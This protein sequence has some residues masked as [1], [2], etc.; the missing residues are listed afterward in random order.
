M[1]GAE[2]VPFT[3][4][5]RMSGIEW[6]GRSI[7]KGAA[8]SV[9]RWV[10][11]QGGRG[12]DRPGA[13]V[14]G[15]ATTGGTP[16]VVAEG[17]RILGVIHLKDTIKTGHGGALRRDA[18][19]GHQ[20]D[21]DH[22]RQPAHG[23]GDR[24]GGRRRRLHGRGHA[25]GQD[26]PHQGGAG[27]RQPGRHDRRRH[28]RRPGPGPGRRR[29]GDEHR[30]PRRPKR[31]ATWSTST[32]TRP[33][34]WRSSRSASSCSSPVA[35]SPP[36]RS[37]TTW[38][39]TSPSSRPC[40]RAVF[41]QL[42]TLN[43]MKLDNPHSA[44]LSAVIFNAI[45]IVLLIPIAL[46]GVK[47]RPMGAAAVLRRNLL[48]YGVGGRDRSVRRHQAHRRGHH[49]TGGALML[50]RQLLTGL[51]V[52]ICLIVLLGVVFPLAVWGVGQVAFNHQAE[53]LIR[54]GQRQGGRLVSDRPELQP[55]RTA[56]RC[57]STSSPVPRP[58][59]TGYD[60]TSSSGTNLGPSNPNLVGNDIGDGQNNPYRTPTDPY[61]V[62]VQASDPSGNPQTDAK[63]DPVYE[64]NSDGTYVCNPNTVPQRVL[65]YREFN[66]LAA[67]ADGAGRRGHRFGLG[68]RPRHLRGQRPR[69]GC[70]GGDSPRPPRE[71]C[72]GPGP[73]AHR[74]R[75]RWGSSVRTASTCWI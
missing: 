53:R 6:E 72:G 69:P 67:T 33:S 44:I 68:S 61:C 37:P 50:R 11:G 47:F 21:H 60:P 38:P 71:R 75:G 8:D 54:Q 65:A 19:H 45:I 35:R 43:I 48:I 36:S 22:R 59:A 18:A 41:P 32:P 4:Q 73:P 56:T 17:P 42:K 30:A 64:K 63:G 24:G 31:P 5:T 23:Q 57:P 39:S 46:R 51:L 3:A 1:P 9:R 20:D 7:R 66:G 70:P 55:T 16:L 2:L 74:C 40:S 58:P 15:I 10:E 13:I 12:A 14:E 62:P 27:R 25:R 26:G 28:Q 29:R 52:T 49:R 34:C